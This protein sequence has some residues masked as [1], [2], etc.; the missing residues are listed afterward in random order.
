MTYNDIYVDVHEI[1]N[2]RLLGDAPAEGNP[3]RTVRQRVAAARRHQTTRF[4]NSS[5][6]NADMNNRDVKAHAKLKPAA[7]DMLDAAA[8]K[9]GLSARAYMRS[10]KLARTIA[11]LDD[12]AEIDTKHVAEALQYRPHQ[13]HDA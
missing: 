9:F 8:E 7:K 4:G 3:S 6:L 13:Y 12:S 10:V 1:D 11:D 2:S 5:K